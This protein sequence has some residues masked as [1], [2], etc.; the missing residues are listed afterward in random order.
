[1]IATGVVA[2]RRSRVGLERCGLGSD[3][4]FFGRDCAVLDR[5]ILNVKTA[6]SFLI[7]A[8]C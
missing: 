1:M 7:V 4:N 3:D 8:G 6:G 2:C 5:I